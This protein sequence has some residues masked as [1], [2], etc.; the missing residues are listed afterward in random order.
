MTHF[1]IFSIC[2]WVG[3]IACLWTQLHRDWKRSRR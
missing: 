3:A 1:I 2:C